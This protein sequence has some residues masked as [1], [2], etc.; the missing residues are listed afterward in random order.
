M[1]SGVFNDKRTR[2]TRGFRL[3]AGFSGSDQLG[4][5]H[6]PSG[7]VC[8]VCGRRSG[9]GFDTDQHKPSYR[10]ENRNCRA[11]I[12]GACAAVE[13]FNGCPFCLGPVR[14]LDA[15]KDHRS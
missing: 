3:Q 13:P 11:I 7:H 14:E 12:C 10:C 4:K 1:N 9:A 8:W 5:D 2:N 6:G 15:P